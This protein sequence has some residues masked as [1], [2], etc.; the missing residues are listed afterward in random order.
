MQIRRK[1]IHDVFIVYINVMSF[2]Y[3]MYMNSLIYIYKKNII[4][5]NQI[6]LW[7]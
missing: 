7:W 5:I 1:I 2:Y 4:K 3:T 6:N